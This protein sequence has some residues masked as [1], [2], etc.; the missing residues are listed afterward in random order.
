MDANPLEGGMEA[1]NDG[2]CIHKGQGL[3]F[4]SSAT[5]DDV[6]IT[7][8]MRGRKPLVC[9]AILLIFTVGLFIVFAVGAEH[10]VDQR[11]LLLGDVSSGENASSSAN[12]TCPGLLQ[13]RWQRASQRCCILL[14]F[15]N[16]YL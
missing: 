12:S 5:S 14:L 16:S 2:L 7:A 13:V 3:E 4:D 1:T 15:V 9:V 6:A 8:K 10:T 11:P